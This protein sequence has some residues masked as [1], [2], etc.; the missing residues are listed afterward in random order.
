M[1]LS[2]L[3]DSRFFP[4]PRNRQSVAR[5][6]NIHEQSTPV[7]GEGH[8]REFG[9]IKCVTAQ[10][11]MLAARRDANQPLAGMVVVYG[12]F[13]QKDVAP[14]RDGQVIGVFHDVAVVGFGEKFESSRRIFFLFGAFK[15]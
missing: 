2:S 9:I 8:T 10:S 15:L 13:A 12:I 3:G 5:I 11:V 1:I 7:R 6:I 14:R 4:R